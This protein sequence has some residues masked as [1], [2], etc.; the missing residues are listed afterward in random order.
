LRHFQNAGQ[1][2]L[3]V[4]IGWNGAQRNDG[5][6]GMGIFVQPDTRGLTW[7]HW[8]N[9]PGTDSVMLRNGRGYAWAALTNTMP[10]DIGHFMNALDMVLWNASDAGVQG[11]PTDLYAQFLSP[12]VPASDVQN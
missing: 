4:D 2:L 5:W 12:D 1:N 3:Y 11:S 8:G 10:E 7:W 9:M 6:Y